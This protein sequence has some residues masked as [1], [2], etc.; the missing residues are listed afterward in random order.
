MRAD[1]PLARKM[2]TLTEP[3]PGAEIKE[4]RAEIGTALKMDVPIPQKDL[5]DAVGLTIS[6]LS[7]LE[8]SPAVP[9]RTALMFRLL[10]AHVCKGKKVAAV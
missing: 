1:N 10:R 3:M 8:N 6:H 9:A 4:I 7:E 2:G 5:A